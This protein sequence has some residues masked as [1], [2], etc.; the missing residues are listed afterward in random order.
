[1]SVVS[2]R[3]ERES[4]TTVQAVI[5][6]H[7]AADDGSEFLRLVE[8]GGEDSVRSYAELVDEAD[9]W[10]AF[11]AAAGLGPGDRVIVVLR[12]SVELYAAYLGA[13]LGGQLP[14]MFAFPSPKL[15]EDEYFR[16]IGSL[17]RGA[18]A[19][20]LVT[21][22]E[23]AQRLAARAGDELGDTPVVTPDAVPATPAVALPEPA[24]GPEDDVLLQYSS[25]TTGLKKGVVVSH[26]ALL[27]QIDAYGEAIGAGPGDRIVS[28]LPL[29][30]DMGL[31]ACLFL[32]LLRRVPLVAMSPFDWVSRPAMW[33]RAVSEHGGTLSWLPNFAYSFMALNVADRDLEGVDLSS[34]RGVV[35]CSEPVLSASHDA[36]VER[37]APHGMTR[38]RLAV[39]YAMAEDTFAVTSAGFGTPVV[40]DHVDGSR[41]DAEHVAAPV[42]PGATGS[43][44]L[45][46]SGRPLP[47]TEL[48]VLAAG[49]RELGEREVGELALRSPC[50]M[51]GYDGNAEAT[52][53]AFTDGWFLTG[54]LGYV[55]DGEVFVTGRSKD[56]L[57]VG[58]KNV[59]PQDIEA[60]VHRVEG[61]VAGRVVAFGVPNDRLG[62][63]DLVVVA[64]TFETDPDQRLVIEREIY[65]VI[66]EHTEVVPGD[67]E[68]VEHR[69]LVKSS[70]GKLARG[71]NRDAHLERR[72]ATRA[73][74]ARAGA[75]PADDVL[76]A[77]RTVVH[78]VVR[79]AAPPSD[80]DALITSGLVDSFA[81]VELL[82]DLEAIAG[83]RLDADLLSDAAAVDTIA[84]LAAVVGRLRSGELVPTAGPT[85][86]PLDVSAIPM[87]YDEP[88]AAAVAGSRWWTLVA[89]MRLRRLGVRPGPG[90]RALGPILLQVDGRPQNIRIGAD[91]TL[92]PWAHLKNRENGV[93]HL[94]DRVRLDTAARIVAANDATVEL[95]EDV[96]LGLGTVVNGGRDV[97]IGRGSFTAAHVV[98]NASDHGTAPGSPMR[99]QMY[100]HAPIHIG[101]DV[102]IG[103]GA[104]VS[105]GSRI[106]HGAVVS[107]G[108]AVSGDVPALAIVQGSPARVIKFR[109]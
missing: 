87:T 59:Y 63:E 74:A 105:K 85:R 80:D 67:V 10:A 15:S 91:V 55:A 30:H 39:S 2:R 58:G 37:F 71:A 44:A 27:W 89:R 1:M 100:E 14:A 32:P 88:R 83:T 4:A 38:D 3:G 22:P 47:Q 102:W 92:M 13:I 16:T 82:A 56:L 21:Y 70:S 24:V 95:G 23:L 78:A 72:S 49:G 93:I 35:N 84:T 5:R 18:R 29:Y 7:A 28:W 41:F 94:H 54:D 46:S 48:R 109:G 106:G 8:S 79:G 11:Y 73:P 36:F 31:I 61:I 81:M 64:E 19:R 51:A 62:T 6:A 25:G 26:R 86:E 57:I 107:A 66:A 40:V 97:R 108:A 99:E 17:L 12:H 98:L 90:L 45:T 101:E 77:V 34:L 52:A 33:P 9:R 53:A 103:A 69:T 60:T 43:R 42:V 65:A 96:A 50:L 68:V 76:V 75:P 20:M 104:L